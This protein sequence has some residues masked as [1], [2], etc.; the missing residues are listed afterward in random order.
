M[1]PGSGQILGAVRGSN[2]DR[3]S[4]RPHVSPPSV[5]MDYRAAL[6]PDSINRARLTELIHYEPICSKA[7]DAAVETGLS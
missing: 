6:C 1:Q 4:S 2:S 7:Q 5:G 3:E